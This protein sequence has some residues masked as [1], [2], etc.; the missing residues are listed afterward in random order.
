MEYR[1]ETT[2]NQLQSER[3]RF[4][5]FFLKLKEAQSNRE[6][7]KNS[8]DL[9]QMTLSKTHGV[10]KCEELRTFC[11]ETDTALTQANK[12]LDQL[13]SHR[14]K[15][16]RA[17]RQCEAAFAQAE[18]MKFIQSERYASTPINFANAMAGLPAITCRQSALRCAGFNNSSSHGLAYR[19]F[20]IVEKVFKY[21]ATDV[22]EAVERMKEH[23]LKAKGREVEPLNALAENWYILRCAIEEV[24]QAERF[25]L[26]ALPFRIIAEYQRRS[27]SQSG[28]KTLRA[29]SEV[30]TTPAFVK[31]RRRISTPGSRKA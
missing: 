30:I 27:E 21:P 19:Q 16:E 7:C 28:L 5:E 31:E 9:A 20:L 2:I 12:T 18:I 6:K 1:G 17:L 8:A 25:P 11:Q 14:E 23:L 22:Q 29:A 10:H 15:L 4:Q 13:Q 24:F 26:E 3:K